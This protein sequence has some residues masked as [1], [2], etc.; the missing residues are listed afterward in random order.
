MAKGYVYDRA[1]F[2]YLERGSRRSAAS[3]VGL[4]ASA[5]R[6]ASVVDIGCGQGSWIAE[7]IKA[8]VAD[9][10]G[11][12]GDYVDRSRLVMPGG[13]FRAHDLGKPFDLGRRFDLVESFETA[14]HIDPA[15]ADMFV[16]N[17]TRHGDLV[18][19]SAAVPGQGGESH[20]NEQ[21]PDYWRQKFLAQGYMAYDWLRPRIR[22]FSEVEPWYRFN[23]LL[24][25]T[26]EG[27]ARLPP[28]VQAAR[29]PHDA[30]VPNLASLAWRARN[31][32]LRRLPQPVVHRLAILKH[33]ARNLA[34]VIDGEGP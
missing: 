31:A 21:P 20:I 19:F 9:C 8:G 33:K 5:L 15:S 10:A 25:A 18:L 17:L 32:C 29:L 28:A 4:V 12:D 30:P 24:F 2:D 14:E 6:P 27:A 16:A 22:S 1:F 23:T 3:V 26:H 11:V 34:S 13:Q 7:W